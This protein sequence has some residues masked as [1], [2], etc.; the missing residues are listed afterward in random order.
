MMAKVQLKQYPLP[1]MSRKAQNDALVQQNLDHH[2]GRRRA[3][4]GTRA[5]PTATAGG[6]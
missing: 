1:E 5:L 3:L 2:D 4:L 6:R